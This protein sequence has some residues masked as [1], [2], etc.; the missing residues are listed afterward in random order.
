MTVGVR[1]L[2]GVRNDHAPLGKL[3]IPSGPQPGDCEFEPRTEHSGP[4]GQWLGHLPFKQEKTGRN[5]LGSQ[6]V[7][8]VRHLAG[9][10]SQSPG[11][12]SQT[13][14][15]GTPHARAGN[16]RQSAAISFRY[17]LI[18][19]ERVVNPRLLVRVQVPE[20][21]SCRA[22][23]SA[24]HPVTMEITGSNPVRTA[25]P[26]CNG[27]HERLRISRRGFES[28]REYASAASS[29]EE[30]RSYKPRIGVRFPGCVRWLW[31]RGSM[32]DCDSCGPG[33]LPGITP[34]QM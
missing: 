18:A 3:V 7:G 25:F 11:F 4:I 15:E 14:H 22:A 19:N 33:S 30:Q 27:K 1:F 10:I 9:L 2:G 6:R 17:P 20:P 12:K 26:W 8:G 5:R 32:R 23:W 29:T 21:W 28:F 31:C 16:G 34:C 24:R 13:R